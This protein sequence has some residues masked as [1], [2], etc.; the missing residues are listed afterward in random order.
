MWDAIVAYHN[1]WRICCSFFSRYYRCPKCNNKYSTPEALDHHIATT[2]HNYTCPHCQK[3]F[4]CERYLRRHL[5]THGTVGKFLSS[6]YLNTVNMCISGQGVCMKKFLLRLPTELFS[7]VSVCSCRRRR[8]TPY[9]AA[10][11]TPSP[12]RDTPRPKLDLT[13]QGPQTCSNLFN[14]FKPHRTRTWTRSLYCFQAG[15]WHST[16]MRSC[17]S[18]KLFCNFSF[19]P[20]GSDG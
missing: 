1:M 18:S 17:Y 6:P 5:P 12:C 20:S 3:V 8:E 4:T 2:T 9:R 10:S 15:G 16:E 13:A 19:P 7:V 14:L 11:P